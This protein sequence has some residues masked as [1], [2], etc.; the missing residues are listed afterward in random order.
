MQELTGIAYQLQGY[1]KWF[2]IC[3]V[4][5]YALERWFALNKGQPFWRKDGGTDVLYWFFPGLVYGPLGQWAAFVL[6]LAAAGRSPEAVNAFLERETV[7][8][9]WPVIVQAAA[10]LLITDFIQYWLHRLFHGRDLWKFH[11][12]HHSA[13]QVDWLTCVRFH[14]VNFVL[15]STLTVSL[16]YLMGF[17]S[18][19]FV[20]LL[21]FNV[22]Y[23]AMVHANLNWTFGPL[24]YVFASPVFHRWHHT[25][26]YE[27]GNKNFAPT[28]PFYDLLFG[29]FYMPEGK[30]PEHYGTDD[31]DV[32][33][34]FLGQMTYPF[35]RK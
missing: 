34:G 21:P 7:W 23:S 27:G 2:L 31:D 12:I 22:L 10:M 4:I 35:I 24:K 11:A 15:Y 28:F 16:T 20:A 14:P 13:R 3:A 8:N 1:G 29:T 32:P 6:L 26:S 5:F 33:D 30:I 25:K 18:E 9:R 19:V 17:S